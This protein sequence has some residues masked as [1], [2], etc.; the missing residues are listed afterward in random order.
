MTPDPSHEPAQPEPRDDSVGSSRRRRTVVS[1]H[2]H[3][4]DETLLTGGT[5]AGAARRGHR[6]V[7]V[8]ATDGAAGLAADR[9]HTAAPGGLRERRRDELERAA[10]ALGVA[11]VELLG[12]PDSG[13]DRRHAASDSFARADP[14]A[15]ATRLAR[16]L[17]R[18]G[19]DVLT[20]YDAHG[21]YGHPDHIQ[22]HHVGR[23]AGQLAGTPV[24]LEATVDR[25]RLRPV[26]AL[27]RLDRRLHIP[28]TNDVF[29][30]RD[31]LTHRVDVRR[32]LAAKR[33]AMTAHASQA[34]AEDGERLLALF[35]R[36]PPAVFRL[37]FAHEWFIQVG[38]P[39][40]R[41]L[42][43]D[44]FASLPAGE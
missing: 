10:S 18:E 14:G 15:A 7:L 41:R 37:V 36:L 26:V 12:Y 3:P 6:V 32:D 35:L 13:P 8:T 21:G 9:F 30:A 19:A 16:I 22:V 28:A 4:D 34:T 31:A 1:F 24:V 39:A 25:D 29:S 38:R 43:G 5:L 17:T 20:I 11:H 27:L 40:G 2:A 42:L 44:I 33:A 23:R